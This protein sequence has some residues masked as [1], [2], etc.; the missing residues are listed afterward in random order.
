VKK[1]IVSACL[2]G[3]S[4]NTHIKME[5]QNL[6][7]PI[8]NNQQNVITPPVGTPLTKPGFA[9]KWWI[10]ISVVILLIG[11]GVTLTVIFYEDKDLVS[12]EKTSRPTTDIVGITSLKLQLKDIE[13]QIANSYKED[14]ATKGGGGMDAYLAGV[15]KRNKLQEEGARIQ[16]EI[17]AKLV[18][19]VNNV[20]AE[21]I[22][23]KFCS[24]SV[25]IDYVK[26]D[27]SNEF[28]LKLSELPIEKLANNLMNN[29]YLD[30][31][32]PE[33]LQY[34][35]LKLTQAS[36]I[37]DG[38]NIYK[39]AAEK[40]YDMV[41]MYR[42]MTLYRFGTD[43][44]RKQFPNA[45]IENNIDVDIKQTYFW[46]IS[47]LYVQS[48]AEYD[49]SAFYQVRW[50]VM[51]TLDN[52]GSGDTNVLTNEEIKSVEDD[53]YNFIKTRYPEIKKGDI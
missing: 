9:K 20:D 43:S 35:G 47:T 40:Y 37:D 28:T 52:W 4:D 23:N 24:G 16:A 21:A 18:S 5:E 49:Q 6:N 25:N 38:L 48:V 30:N 27:Y 44:L 39:C 8:Q 3:Y 10:I 41:S 29:V 42:M 14:L 19:N 2:V 13:A 50:N 53:A 51:S 17:D 1:I 33:A 12:T 46:L 11:I 26:T 22:Y 34:F 36:K 15:D 7:V 32:I 45:I 31:Q